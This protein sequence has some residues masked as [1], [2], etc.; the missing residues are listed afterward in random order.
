MR[1][2]AIDHPA[3]STQDIRALEARGFAL[4]QPMMQRAG[5]SAAEF[6]HDQLSAASHVLCLIGP[7]NNGGDA[8]VAAKQLQALGHHVTAVM[9]V[10]NPRAS[11]DA[12]QA[13]A[14][15][16]AAGGTLQRTMPEQCPDL[17]MD[18]LF[19]IGL[20]RPLTQPW[21]AVIH[22][23]NAWQTRVL[24]LDI[25]SGLAADSGQ[26]LGEPIRADWTLAFLAPSLAT[27]AA[28]AQTWCGQCWLEDLDLRLSGS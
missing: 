23:V 4:G 19:G 20:D 21:Q 8:L 10:G 18:G 22:T 16:L 3:K 1:S 28:Q 15:W 17:V 26:A 2:P 13:L 24:A 7:G 9:P 27:R 11:S 6:A 14:N 25:P 12:K 5:Q